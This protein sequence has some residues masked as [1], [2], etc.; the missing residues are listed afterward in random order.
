[1]ASN[2]QKTV[3]SNLEF[4]A[5]RSVKY[6]AEIKIFSNIPGLKTCTSHAAFYKQVPKTGLTKPRE[7]I[8]KEEDRVSRKQ[9]V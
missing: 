4:S 1:M 7:K 3:L 2:F 6:E 9:E 5:K 8:K